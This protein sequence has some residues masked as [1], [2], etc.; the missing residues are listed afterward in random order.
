[1]ARGGSASFS[2]PSARASGRW[3][4]WIVSNPAELRLEGELRSAAE[5]FEMYVDDGR[6]YAMLNGWMSN[7][8]DEQ[9]RF[10]EWMPTARLQV[11][12]PR[13]SRSSRS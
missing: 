6:V 2:A 3:S 10:C 5:P 8:C 11:I 13:P 1:M 7:V 12:R 9:T 4:T